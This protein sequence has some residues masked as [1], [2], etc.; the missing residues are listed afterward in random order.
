MI[1]AIKNLSRNHWICLYAYLKKGRPHVLIFDSLPCN[2]TFQVEYM[3]HKFA[4]RIGAMFNLK[5]W[6]KLDECV[7]AF[8]EEWPT[9]KEGYNCGPIALKAAELA[10]HLSV[11]SIPD[12]PSEI[13]KHSAFRSLKKAAD[14]GQFCREGIQVNIRKWMDAN[15]ID[16]C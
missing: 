4:S 6:K 9:Q 1:V 3:G 14:P 10:V 5:A 8:P 11:S 13:T 12:N 15:P 7:V 16:G 2:D